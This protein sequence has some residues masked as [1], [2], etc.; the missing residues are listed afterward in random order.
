[1]TIFQSNVTSRKRDAK[2]KVEELT[3]YV[4]ALEKE[5]KEL[6]KQKRGKR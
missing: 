1:M 5:V 3:L 6:K 4:I 2:Q